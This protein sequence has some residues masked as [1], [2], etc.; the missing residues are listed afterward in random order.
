MTKDDLIQARG[1]CPPSMLTVS[2]LCAACPKPTRPVRFLQWL[3]EKRTR[4]LCA[5]LWRTA[6]V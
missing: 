5:R 2:T 6:Y 4:E 1:L 3:P